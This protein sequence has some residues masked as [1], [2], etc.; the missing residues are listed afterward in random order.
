[1]GGL[2]VPHCTKNQVKVFSLAFNVLP[3]LTQLPPYT[4]VPS[5]SRPHG[6]HHFPNTP[7]TILPMGLCARCFF[8]RI[9][10]V[11]VF[12]GTAHN[13]EPTFSKNP[14]KRPQTKRLPLSLYSYSTQ[15]LCIDKCPEERLTFVSATLLID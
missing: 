8:I 4:A 14:T 3:K 11:C 9:L 15:D 13:P 10:A 7:C 5:I 6:S 2:L 12:Q 1:M